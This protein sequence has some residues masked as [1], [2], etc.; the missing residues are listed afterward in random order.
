MPGTYDDGA[1]LFATTLDQGFE[2]VVSKRR[3][4]P[5]SPGV[6]SPDWIKAPHRPLFSVVVGGWR[7]DRHHPSRIEELLLGMPAA[8]GLHYIGWVRAGLA[9]RS[10]VDLLAE[11]HPRQRADSP[12]A[13]EIGATV[14]TGVTWV[15]PGVVVDVRAVGLGPE[16]PLR[17]PSYQR[18][19]PDM[20]PDAILEEI[21]D[22]EATTTGDEGPYARS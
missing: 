20:D 3:D 21:P 10:Q 8:G 22:T 4:S 2:G 7:P 18:L 15:D 9:E 12:F 1:A 14:A 5:Y 19:R 16:G 11:L 17:Q 13:E 6:R